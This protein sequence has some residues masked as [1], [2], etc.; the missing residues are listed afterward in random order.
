MSY[1]QNDIEM[2]TDWKDS[3]FRDK[4]KFKKLWKELQ[5]LIQ[6]QVNKWNAPGLPRS[7]IESEAKN[8]AI[9]AL[10]DFNPA[11]GFKLSTFLVNRMK[12]IS[13]YVYKFQNVGKIPEQRITKIDGFNKTKAILVDRLGREP[14]GQELSEELKWSMSDVKRMEKE[15]R[16]SVVTTDLLSSMSTGLD[17]HHDDLVDFI[18]MELDP[19]EKTVYEYLLGI[20]G[21]KELK[22]KDIAKK[23]RMSPSKITRIRKSIEKKIEKYRKYR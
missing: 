1:G 19:N 14:N 13:R 17:N 5:P 23:M 3:G 12:K 7:A 18:Y 20:N 15:L 22:G 21:K 16:A 11:F 4:K 9:K 10:P 6:S 2:W 8:L